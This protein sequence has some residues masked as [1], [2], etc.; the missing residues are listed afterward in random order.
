LEANSFSTSGTGTTTT[1][2]DT[3]TNT[4]R[5]VSSLG[6]KS[7]NLLSYTLGGPTGLDQFHA[8]TSNIVQLQATNVGLRNEHRIDHL[9]TR[10]MQLTLDGAHSF[11]D[12]LKVHTLLGWTESHHRNPIQTTLAADLGCMGSGST[13]SYTCGAGTASNPYVYDYTKG[14][15]PLLSTGNVDPTSVAGW[16]LSNVREREEYAFN[17][18]RSGA[19]DFEWS[20]TKEIKIS[21]G[22]DYRNYGFGS[23]ELRRSSGGSGEDS[24]IPASV[25][26]VALSSYTTTVSLKG[27]DVPS[28]SNTSWLTTNFDK[29]AT[30]IHLWDPTVFP[31]NQAPGISN[32]GTVREDDYG[33]W[34]QAG[35]DTVVYGSLSA[36]TPECVMCRRIRSPTATPSAAP[37]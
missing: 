20:P 27:L 24:T 4:A 8:A 12:T 25:R 33:A 16:F 31:M 15:M 19:A 1:Y 36:A 34:L 5:Y 6:I 10:F 37:A 9:D 13:G 2:T 18:Y 7:I 17:S 29:A 14:D 21:G 32:S 28:G 22:L 11:S 3:T 30:Q 35:W 26:S 23:L